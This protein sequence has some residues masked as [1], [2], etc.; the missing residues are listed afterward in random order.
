MTEL[1]AVATHARRPVR[2]VAPGR[3]TPRCPGPRVASL[4]SSPEKRGSTAQAEPVRTVSVWASGHTLPIAVR[5]LG[6]AYARAARGRV[7]DG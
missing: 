2:A 6:A 4:A 3:A 5:R 7:S 1:G